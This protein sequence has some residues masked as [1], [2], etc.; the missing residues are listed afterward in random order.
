MHHTFVV[1]DAL[2]PWSAHGSFALIVTLGSTLLVTAFSGRPFRRPLSTGSRARCV[3]TKHC[4]GE[5]QPGASCKCLARNY[6][7]APLHLLT[8]FSKR[9]RSSISW[10]GPRRGARVPASSLSKAIF[11]RTLDSLSC[12]LSLIFLGRRW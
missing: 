12:A 8:R 4:S 6:G 7:L 1:G 3:S 5:N 11:F 10:P 2:W 9:S